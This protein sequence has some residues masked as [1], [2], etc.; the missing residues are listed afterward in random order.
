MLIRPLQHVDIKEYK[1]LVHTVLKW[2]WPPYMDEGRVTQIPK[3]T[4]PQFTLHSNT[5]ASETNWPKS[6]TA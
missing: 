4:L 3:F 2:L 5:V 1:L 6:S